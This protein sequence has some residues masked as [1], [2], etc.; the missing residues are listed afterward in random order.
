MHH[1]FAGVATW[2][3]PA[4]SRGVAGPTATGKDHV[5]MPRVGCMIAGGVVAAD[6]TVDAIQFNV[7]MVGTL[8]TMPGKL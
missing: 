3:G 2:R 6:M 8:F 4:P 5:V 7:P 1:F